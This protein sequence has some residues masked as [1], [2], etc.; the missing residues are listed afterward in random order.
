MF[1]QLDMSENERRLVSTLTRPSAIPPSGP[2]D[3]DA[4]VPSASGHGPQTTKPGRRRRAAESKNKSPKNQHF[5]FVDQNSSSKEKRAHVMRHHVQ[6]KKKQRKMSGTLST[7]QIPDHT[8]Y[9]AKKET[10]TVEETRLG[11]P[12]TAAQNFPSGETSL[13]IRFSNMR[14]QPYT[15]TLP[16]IGSPITILDASR[17]DPFASLPMQYDNSDIQLADYWRD[18]LMYWSGQNLHV[19]NQIF[20]TAMGNPL[21]FKAVVLS[22][23]ARWKAQLYNMP[24][25][26][27]I[28]RHVGQAV[29]LIDDVSSGSALIRADDLTMALSGMALHEGRFGNKQ[30]AQVYVDRAVQ[31]MRPRTGT[32]RPVEVFLH[33]VRYLMTPEG[34]WI[35]LV[36]QQW[37]VSFLRGA[38]DLM[39]QH[40]SPDYLLQAP[41]RLKAFQMES[42]LF[43]LLSSGPRPSQV[44]H[45]SRVYVVRDAHTQEVSQT[46][47]LIY[48]TAA[49]WTFNES[50]DKTDRFLQFLCTT[51]KQ[52][53]LDRDP[54]CETL[55]WL[56]LEEGYDSDLQDPERAWSTGELLKA[57]KQL[58]PDLQFQF[59][60]ILMSF[61]SFQTPIRGVTAFEEDLR[62]S[63][64][65]SQ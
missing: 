32:N 44:P 51:V 7:E 18:K 48:I 9:P 15:S 26:S 22:Y 58:R 59:N 12:S 56:L 21:S 27:D 61:L 38:E 64:H 2:P 11:S 19:K 30:L 5:Y 35:G 10:G 57:H 65:S 29:K 47:S 54:A 28:Q 45:A 17:R 41:H 4:S 43:S 16:Y 62:Q 50:P 8:S 23:C 60:E 39:R 37:L 3:T 53:H 14:S 13:Q 33:Y 25:S 52:H 20:R 55:L 36:E 1:P 63:P 40:S 42:P 46:A 31:V 49:L 34:S 24:D 6:E